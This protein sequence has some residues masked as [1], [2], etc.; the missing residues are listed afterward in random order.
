[1]AA[2]KVD[3]LKDRLKG[4][5]GQLKAAFEDRILSMEDK[6][7]NIEEMMKKVLDL[8]VQ[9]VA[10]EASALIERNANSGN[11]RD[12][13]NVEILEEEERRQFFEPPP[14]R[15]IGK[16][17]G[18]LWHVEAK[19]T[20]EMDLK[21]SA[22]SIPLWLSIAN[23][24]EKV[25]G[26]SKDRAILTMGRKRNPHNPKFW[27]TPI[28][29][30]LKHG[31][32]KE[33]VAL[34]EKALQECPTSGILWSRGQ[35]KRVRYR[36]SRSG[37]DQSEED[38]PPRDGAAHSRFPLILVATGL[39][40]GGGHHLR[41]SLRAPE[42]AIGE[43]HASTVR[44]GRRTQIRE[45]NSEVASSIKARE[46]DRDKE[47]GGENRPKRNWGRVYLRGN[48]TYVDE[49]LQL[50]RFASKHSTLLRPSITK[51]I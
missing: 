18:R 49:E 51:Y 11:R 26:L 25:N 50:H 28:H 23:L 10:L 14:R 31:N 41:S 43:E 13:H 45:D 36:N 48:V 6:F 21:Y 29:A 42:P 20:Y 37:A 35:R 19:E 39:A 8:H 44:L 40:A 34:M 4:E 2:K 24:K 27:L 30:E 15:G 22:N 46:R 3:A 7:S 17:V 47:K 5:V 1:M 33:A 38:D 32:K 16:G 9:P 12:D